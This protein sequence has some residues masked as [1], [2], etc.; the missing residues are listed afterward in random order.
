MRIIT[1]HS[2]YIKF[3]ALKKALKSLDLTKEPI[4]EQDVKEPLVVLTAV[5]K[6]DD[7][8]TIKKL[9]E[10][11]KSIS[12]QVKASTI[13]LYPYAHLSSNLGSP[14]E[15]QAL[16]QDAEKILKKSFKKVVRAPFGYYKSFEV[17]VKGHP[18]AE[19]SREIKSEGKAEEKEETYD[20]R[21]LLREISKSKLDTSKLKPNDHRILGQKLDLFSFNDVSPG[22]I[23][24]HKNGQTIFT[25]LLN[26]SREMHNKYKYEEVSTPQILENK[27]WKI[28]GHW[29]HY[30]ENMFLTNYENKEAAIK[31]MNC[32]GMMLIY[33]AQTRSYKDLPI[34]MFEFG[35][36]HR[37]ELSGVLAGLFRVVKFTQDDAHIFLTEKHIQKEMES[38]FSLI[39]DIYK[40]T[41]NFEYGFELSTMPKKAMGD[42][43]L[44]DK[45]EK[46]LEA[47]LKKA[48][49]KYKV[50]KGDGA[51]YGPKIDLH[52]K[53]SLGRKWQCAT[54][55]LDM[56]MPERFDLKFIDEKGKE[57][58]PLI[59]HRA[60]FGSLE[61]F[62]G[63]LLEHTNGQLPTWLSP[64]QARVINYTDRN[65]KYAEQV[66]KKLKE[67]LP[68]LRV[69]TDIDSVPLSGKIRDA[70]MMKIPYI[71]V[72]G[73]K[74]QKAKKI[75]VRRGG[76]KNITNMTIDK[77]IKNIDKE[78]KERR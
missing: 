74:E 12:K 13:V 4:E 23:Y 20:T 42:K 17:K 6:G 71:I 22:S 5:E 32:P 43:I 45:A 1:L 14:K 34:R 30:K 46:A 70:E 75:A 55:Q 73:D 59:L 67:K 10:E 53:D 9:V 24:W 21:Q 64:I 65:N 57:R 33:K 62:I 39:D 48:K 58:Q 26:F 52:I 68:N 27:L 47:A 38:L 61:R 76:S 11:I 31:P 18:M 8:N 78:I 66:V 41:F 54:I 16:L 19:L 35:T 56:Q 7:K 72:V 28:S 63:I 40:K 49:V 60:I 69:D 3:K 36:V 44:W 50:N 2:D 15:A 29:G 77:F 51:F 37:K 25:E